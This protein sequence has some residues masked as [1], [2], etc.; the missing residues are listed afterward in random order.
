MGRPSAPTMVSSFAAT[1]SS[2]YEVSL[3]SARAERHTLSTSRPQTKSIEPCCS[4][5]GSRLALA[6]P[7]SESGI[8]PSSRTSGGLIPSTAARSSAYPSDAR[9]TSHASRMS[10][11]CCCTAAA[12][13]LSKPT[14]PPA[15]RA[16]V[17]AT[18]RPSSPPRSRA[19][20]PPQAASCAPDAATIAAKSSASPSEMRAPRSTNASAAWRESSATAQYSGMRMMRSSSGPSSD[21]GSGTASTSGHQTGLAPAEMSSAENGAATA[22]GDVKAMRLPARGSAASGC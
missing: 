13:A 9:R 8:R 1:L 2:V 15:T 7:S 19:A 6:S 14:S 12:S 5:H 11:S 22:R 18:P 17:Q 21:S 10:G 4:P 3:S 16:S 20:A